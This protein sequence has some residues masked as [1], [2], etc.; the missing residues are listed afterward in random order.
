MVSKLSK[1]GPTGA[2]ELVVTR[3]E[4][5]KKQSFFYQVAFGPVACQTPLTGRSFDFLE[6]NFTERLNPAKETINFGLELPLLKKTWFLKK[7][8]EKIDPA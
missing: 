3:R 4:E 8:Y 5:K 2:S 1:L 6:G 7:I